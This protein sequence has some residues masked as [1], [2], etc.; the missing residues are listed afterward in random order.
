MEE[1]LKHLQKATPIYPL[2][3]EQELIRRV[4]IGDRVGAKE[5]LNRLLG[6]IIVKHSG[7]IDLLKARFL[8]LMVILSRAAVEAGASLEQLL[9]INYQYQMNSLSCMP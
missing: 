1:T 6:D 2:E 7:D 9:G 4:E 5:I 3:T 8:E